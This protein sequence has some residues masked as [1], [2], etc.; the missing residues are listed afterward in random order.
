M[1]TIKFYSFDDLFLPVEKGV[2]GLTSQAIYESLKYGG[3]RI[4]IWGGQQEH[5]K[6]DY[7]ISLKGH[8][9]HNKPIKIFKG[10]CLI[11]SLDGSAGSITY[12]PEKKDGQD[13]FFALNHHAGILRCKDE[14]ILNL[15]FF[16]YRYE[17]Q[18]RN[19]T[20]SEGSKTLSLKTLKK[21][22]YEIPDLDT[23]KKILQTYKKLD[24]LKKKLTHITNEIKKIKEKTLDCEYIS[25]ASGFMPISKILSYVSR[26]DSLSEEGLYNNLKYE[27][28]DGI[29]DVLSGSTENQHYGKISVN[30]PNIHILKNRQ[31]IHIV[32]RG[33]AGKLSYLPKGVYATNTN[34]FLL[35][36]KK[37]AFKDINITNE[38]EEEYY[39]KFLVVFLQPIFY[40]VSS[41]SDLSVF[42]LTEIMNNL[43]IPF[44]KYCKEMK[45][46]ALKYDILNKYES[47]SYSLINKIDKLFTKQVVTEKM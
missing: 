43:E 46:I 18:L 1:T 31:C 20:V 19:L 29:V 13:Y 35:Y 47:V 22:D 3:K 44:L 5:T 28:K 6:E 4:P 36:P 37:E 26:N 40:E 41:K 11:I 23:Q 14:S 45:N 32:T 9:K 2:F 38:T 7:F 25:N 16:K 33:K 30:T 39:L 42:P 27:K 17:Q 15:K 34:A 8:S 12:K 21:I 24:V 10:D